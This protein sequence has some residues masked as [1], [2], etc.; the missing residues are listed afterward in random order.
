MKRSVSVV[1][2]SYDDRDLLAAHLPAVLAELE[3]RAAGDELIV[4]DDGA[5]GLVEWAAEH[6]PGARV[7][8]RAENGGFAEAVASG[9]RAARC[10][11]VFLMNPDVRPRAGFLE[12]LVAALADPDTAAAAPYVLLGGERASEESLSRLAWKRGFPLLELADHAFEAGDAAPPLPAAF[13]LGGASLWR[14]ADLVGE[15]ALDPLFVPF[16][17]EDVDRSW[18]AWRAGRRVV[19]CP[20]SVVEHHHRGT[21]G[22]AVPRSIVRAAIEKNRLLFTWKHVDDAARMR[23]HLDGLRARLFAAAAREDR[24]SIIWLCLALQELD[25]A[26]AARNELPPPVAGFD[27]LRRASD[28]GLAPLR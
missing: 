16:Y 19:V 14:R 9:V 10:E 28:A 4:V 13:A 11:L 26:L 20:S 21:I 23:E 6:A 3:R 2:P 18:R 1:V 22:R 27:E 5:G 12:P 17:F 25:A 7:V 8:E 15:G 24:E